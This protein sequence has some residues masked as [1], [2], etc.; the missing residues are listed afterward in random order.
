MRIAL[1]ALGVRA[2]DEV[3]VPCVSAAA[4][5][6]AVMQLQATPIFVDISTDN[7]TMDP[8]DAMNKKSQ[9]TK[10]AIPVHLYG[11]PARLKELSA[12]R[13]PLIEDAA[14]AHGSEAP[15]GRCGSFGAAAAFS[16][17]PTKNLGAYGD[18][19]MIVTSNSEIARQCRLLRNYGQRENYVSEIP[20]D[21]SRLDELQAAVLR[22][23]LKH[24][25]AANRRRR[26]IA[27]MY[28]E[29][30]AG[31]P[32]VLQKETGKSNYHLFVVVTPERDALRR[33]LLAEDIPTAIHYPMPLHRQ[34]AFEMLRQSRLNACPNADQLC[35]RVLSLPM[36][37]HLATHEVERVAS[38]VRSFFASRR[39]KSESG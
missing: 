23:K 26:E 32:L 6:M 19:G 18:G 7:F 33:H 21:N 10:A 22:V 37:A 28:R 16:F 5:A 39:V 29:A 35:G 2:G 4:T 38:A 11:M 15:W 8:T 34:K 1:A 25:D 9:R 31:L 20:G 27:A 12:L 24:L 3:L 36:H 30:F 13:L 14:Q 17:Y